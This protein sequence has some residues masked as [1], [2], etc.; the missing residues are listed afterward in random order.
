MIEAVVEAI[1]AAY[2]AGAGL[3]V[4]FLL[5]LLLG[6]GPKFL[7][8]ILRDLRHNPED[9]VFVPAVGFFGLILGGLGL[10]LAGLL[11]PGTVILLYQVKRKEKKREVEAQ[12]LEFE[13]FLSQVREVNA[14]LPVRSHD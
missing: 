1:V 10:W 3:T 4:L 2:R 9:W 6:R 11:W 12:T 5:L 14:E 13:A 7:R 8:E